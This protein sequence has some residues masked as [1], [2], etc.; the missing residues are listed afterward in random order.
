MIARIEILL[1][2]RLLLPNPRCVLLGKAGQ[3]VV[4]GLPIGIG[5]REPAEAGCSSERAS[6]S[7]EAAD[8]LPR[9]RRLGRRS[10]RQGLVCV[11][12]REEVILL[13]QMAGRL[14]VAPRRMREAGLL[15]CAKACRRGHRQAGIFDAQVDP[16]WAGGPARCRHRRTSLRLA[17]A[18]TVVRCS[19]FRADGFGGDLS[20]TGTQPTSEPRMRNGTAVAGL[21]GAGLRRTR[22]RPSFGR[23]GPDRREDG[24][25]PAARLML[26]GVSP[27]HTLSPTSRARSP[28]MVPLMS[29]CGLGTGRVRRL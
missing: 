20:R 29:R 18:Q 14:A 23:D 26:R 21:R 12:E 10:R 19:M 7:G 17:P 25:D 15:L 13:L 27:Q 16:T 3:R 9:W 22:W 6:R 8:C 2:G 5:R 4:S 1:R 24:A 11:G 28:P